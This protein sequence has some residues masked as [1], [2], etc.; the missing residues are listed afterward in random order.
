MESSIQDINKNIG[1]IQFFLCCVFHL[2]CYHFTST[3]DDIFYMQIPLH[4]FCNE[5]TSI[6]GRE[7]KCCRCLKTKVR[8]FRINV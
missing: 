3:P 2:H 4:W 6:E 8:K 1:L 5:M 7:V